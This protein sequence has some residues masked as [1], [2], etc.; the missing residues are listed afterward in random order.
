MFPLLDAD[1][2]GDD[3]RVDPDYG[4]TNPKQCHPNVKIVDV[5]ILDW[6]EYDVREHIVKAK[7]PGHQ[8]ALSSD[9]HSE[10]NKILNRIK[11]E[12]KTDLRARIEGR[13][14]HLQKIKVEEV[15]AKH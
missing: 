2:K 7:W 15:A 12:C 4:G 13:A 14:L 11:E 3:I 8:G 5:K 9:Q 1:T 10:V 6:D